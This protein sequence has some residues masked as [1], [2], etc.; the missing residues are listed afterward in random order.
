MLPQGS[1]GDHRQLTLV[2]LADIVENVAS[3]AY[4]SLDK[5][6][7][8]DI[9]SN[10]GC[11]LECLLVYSRVVYFCLYELKRKGQREVFQDVML[12]DRLYVS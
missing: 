6:L 3:A 7:S 12:R 5:A 10:H 9:V 2:R 11:V 1:G 8:K 4:V